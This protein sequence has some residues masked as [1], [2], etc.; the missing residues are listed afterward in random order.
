[1]S[2]R[3]RALGAL[4]IALASGIGAAVVAPGVDRF[5]T[6]IHDAVTLPDDIGTCGRDYRKDA[7]DRRWSWA[8]ITA[9]TD[10]GHQPVVVNPGPLTG[11][12]V[13]CQS[14]ACTTASC[15]TVVWVRIDW[16]AYVDY[17]LQGGP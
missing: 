15:N 13:P 8:D 4:V 16:D 11:L 14:E 17:S 12:L 5:L 3:Q 1:M 2:R 10:P 7:L 9:S 6:G